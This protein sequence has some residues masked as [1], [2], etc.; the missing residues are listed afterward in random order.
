MKGKRQVKS[1]IQISR[2]T[3]GLLSRTQ[4]KKGLKNLAFSILQAAL[5]VLSAATIIPL[6]YLLIDNSIPQD[7]TLLQ[8]MGHIT[9]LFSWPSILIIIIIVFLCKNVIS[10]LLIHNQSRFIKEIS[11]SF[12]ERLYRRF[13]HQQWTE[14]LHENSAET[15]RKIKT[16]PSDFAN[17]VLQGHL[18]VATDACI[19][20]LMLCGM[21]WF[22]YRIIII[23][24]ILFVPIAGLYQLFRKKIISKIN[25]SFR[26]LTPVGNIVLTQGIDS[27]AETKIYHKKNFFIRRFMDIRRITASHLASLTTVTS[28]PAK[29]F[30]VMGVLSFAAV[31]LYS[32]LVNL[33][34][35]HLIVWLGLLSISMYRIIPSINRMLVSLSQ[36]QAYSYSLWELKESFHPANEYAVKKEQNLPFVKSIQLK[37]VSYQYIKGSAEFQLK[38]VVISFNKGDFVLLEGPSGSG[39]TTLI[40]VLAGLIKDYDGSILIDDEP[41]STSTCHEWQKKIGFSPQASI[42]LQDTILNNIAFGEEEFE[43]ERKH[44]QTALEMAGLNE[45]VNRLPLRLQTQVGENGLTLSG[46]QRQRLILARALYRN[47]D[48]LLLDEVTNQL[49]EGNKLKIFSTLKEFSRNGKTI[50]IAAHDPSARNF[51]TRVFSFDNKIVQEVQPNS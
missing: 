46:G 29:F 24:L 19:C 33:E 28:L 44:V 40:H 18:Q 51:A 48:I 30:E 14:Y 35:D 42:V 3:F 17:Y 20:L 38:D 31:I 21:L 26:E 7:S 45:F 15:V 5:E 34:K 27:F 12:S 13:Y 25:T 6:F 39:K 32:K 49:D 1:I 23:V 10:L 50:V 47:P 36:I 22:D 16:T 37:K 4:Q 2:D 9:D 41:L 8:S 43:I 11:V